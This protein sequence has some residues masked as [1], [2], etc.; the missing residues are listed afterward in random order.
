MINWF[1]VNSS[2]TI[3]KEK[4]HNS[5]DIVFKRNLVVTKACEQYPVHYRL[6]LPECNRSRV[7][8][9]VLASQRHVYSLCFSSIYEEEEEKKFPAL[10]LK[11]SPCQSQRKN[12]RLSHSGRTRTLQKESCNTLNLQ[13]GRSFKFDHGWF[14]R[15]KGTT[16]GQGNSSER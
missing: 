7:F 13:K 8:V 2:M 5:R 4:L 6:I 14:S 11:I 1:I 10:N 12:K 9:S 16:K 3:V 15:E